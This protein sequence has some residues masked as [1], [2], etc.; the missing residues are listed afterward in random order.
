M[1]INSLEFIVVLLQLAASIVAL[2][3]GYAV[4]ILGSALPVIPHLLVWTDNT[5]SKSWANRVTTS[6]RKAQPL[7]GILS[8]LLRRTTVGFESAHIAAVAND[9][10]NTTSL[11]PT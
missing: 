7:V 2:K 1:H 3:S 4:S 10:P 6:S 9:V 11:A 8:A 5:A